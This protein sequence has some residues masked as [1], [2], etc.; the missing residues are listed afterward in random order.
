MSQA[1]LWWVPILNLGQS[2][3]LAASRQTHHRPKINQWSFK[4]RKTAFQSLRVEDFFLGDIWTPKNHCLAAE[5]LLPYITSLDGF[6]TRATVMKGLH[7]G[8]EESDA[9][10]EDVTAGRRSCHP[11]FKSPL[12]NSFTHPTCQMAEPLRSATST[13]N[14]R[15][16]QETFT[17]R[18][19]TGTTQLPPRKLSVARFLPTILS[20]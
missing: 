4:H 18:H 19:Q 8:K 11:A 17:V 5:R 20:E 6:P 3:Q 12:A 7:N 1:G 14:Q 16:K 13:K 9:R 15:I 10:R 2:V